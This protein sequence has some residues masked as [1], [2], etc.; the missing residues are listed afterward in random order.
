MSNEVE[1]CRHFHAGNYDPA[2]VVKD[3][4]IQVLGNG[5]MWCF[6]CK[7]F[8]NRAESQ[9]TVAQ[10]QPGREQ[11]IAPKHLKLWI[12]GECLQPFLYGTLR[13]CGCGGVRD[14]AE[15]RLEVAEYHRD[16][17]CVATPSP[18]PA[19]QRCVECGHDEGIDSGGFCQHLIVANDPWRG[20]TRLCN[21]KCVFTPP[22]NSEELSH[23][24][25][26]PSAC[27]EDNGGQCDKCV[28]AVTAT[29]ISTLLHCCVCGKGFDPIGL[30]L[31]FEAEHPDAALAPESKVS[32]REVV[33]SWGKDADGY[34]IPI[35]S[36]APSASAQTEELLQCPFCGHAPVYLTDFE[37]D[38]DGPTVHHVSCGL[39][40]VQPGI[41]GQASKAE[42]FRKWNS[43]AVN[44]TLCAQHQKE[45]TTYIFRG[46]IACFEQDTR[47]TPS[48]SGDP[49]KEAE[50]RRQAEAMFKDNNLDD[51]VDMYVEIQRLRAAL[52]TRSLQ[53]PAVIYVPEE[54]VLRADDEEPPAENYEALA[55]EIA[56]DWYAPRIGTDERDALRQRI[57]S[58]LSARSS[59]LDEK[60]DRGGK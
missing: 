35:P 10:V 11:R 3:Q 16:D 46:C 15:V 54:N 13:P 44:I 27:T 59:Q 22:A 36:P 28:E 18:V 33:F 45:Y 5:E 51:P 32:E 26:N 53:R 57:A 30:R 58:A 47:A 20:G 40:Y 21:H 56:P 31:H 14:H 17:Q 42:A 7:Q 50:W 49:V 52:S 1:R 8:F 29:G 9:T 23:P 6:D 39:C 25:A 2:K 60:G 34:P 19:E 12:C 24:L 37:N 55:C 38:K 43:R 4:P 48:L 41:Y